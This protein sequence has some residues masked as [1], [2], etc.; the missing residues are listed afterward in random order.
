MRQFLSNQKKEQLVYAAVYTHKF[1]SRQHIEVVFLFFPE[2]GFDISYN[3]SP[4]E[5][6]CTKCQLLFV[7]NLH[8]MTKSVSGKN[9]KKYH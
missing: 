5:T 4:M 9:K 8:E 2:T 6:M 3:L 7:D 1:F